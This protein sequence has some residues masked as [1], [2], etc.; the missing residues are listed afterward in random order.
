MDVFIQRIPWKGFAK[1]TL[2]LGVDKLVIFYK[3]FDQTIEDE[4]LYKGLHLAIKNVRRGESAW[5]NVIFG[6]IITSIVLFLCTKMSPSLLFKAIV[7]ILNFAVLITAG[8]LFLQRFIKREY[9]YLFDASGE[10][11]LMLRV[12]PGSRP[13]IAALRQ[14]I[15]TVRKATA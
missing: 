1:Q 11:I 3:G 4:Y 5:T 7:L 15:E 6:L 13:F 10:C 2:T 14:N 8:A 9:V 12:T